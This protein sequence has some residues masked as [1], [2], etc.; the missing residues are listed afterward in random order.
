MCT[1]GTTHGLGILLLDAL[2]G[3]DQDRHTVEWINEETLAEYMNL[4]VKQ[5]RKALRFLEQVSC[6]IVTASLA[7][8]RT[9]GQQ[10]CTPC[11][12]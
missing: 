10:H 5:A 2:C 8:P 6:T 1:Q 12:S 11:T 4:H 7:L 9:P 3:I